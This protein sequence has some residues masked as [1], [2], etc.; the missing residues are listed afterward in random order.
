MGE[1]AD[2]MVSMGEKLAKDSPATTEEDRSVSVSLTVVNA[3]TG[4]EIAEVTAVG[5]PEFVS[6]VIEGSSDA[7]R[8]MGSA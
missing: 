1:V 6:R 7:L 8:D 5:D 3:A 2:L 4:A